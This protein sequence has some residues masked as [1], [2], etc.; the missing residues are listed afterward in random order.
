MIEFAR[1][2]AFAAVP[3]PI[4]AWLLLPPLR[5]RGAL[6]VPASIWHVLAR[7]SKHEGTRAI[8]RPPLFVLRTVGWLALVFALAGPLQRGAPLIQPTGR[9]LMIALDVSASMAEID[10]EAG[11]TRRIDQ[12]RELL[13]TFIVGRAGD[14]IGLI[15]FA[16]D[17]HLISPLTFDIRA[18]AEMLNEMSVGLAGRRTDLGQAIGLAIKALR[19][20]ASSDRV[21][22]VI[23]DGETNLG[24]LSAF[25]AATLAA[26]HNIL[27]HTIGFAR[28]IAEED[29]AQ[30]AEIAER[31]GGRFFQAVD[32]TLLDEIYAEIDRLVAIERPDNQ[33][34][35]IQDL[36]WFP[37][38]LALAVLSLLAWREWRTS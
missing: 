37:L 4:V 33:P 8:P 16:E 18:V 2:W 29:A 20:E 36:T 5:E 21:L 17:A 35:L 15:G 1:L 31:T 24:D 7:L 26:S 34:R 28:N 25:D 9:D 32:P 19:D 14:R 10:T 13:E 3:L 6:I 22:V 11:D 12:V 30:L 38:S 27:I 23:S